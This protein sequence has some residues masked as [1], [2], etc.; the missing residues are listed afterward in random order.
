VARRP[1][2]RLT[3]IV[4][5]LV[6][7]LVVLSGVSYS[8]YERARRIAHE[9][10]RRDVEVRA[11][12]LAGVLER[13]KD[14][15]EFDLDPSAVTEY[16]TVGEAPFLSIADAAGKVVVKSP[17]LGELDFAP[18]TDW[19][20]DR[21]E[22]EELAS[23]PHGV[24]C[25]AVT[26]SF[27]VRVDKGGTKPKPGR[28][29]WVPPTE[30]E[31]R[32]NIHVAVDSRDRDAALASLG[33]F[34]VV[35]DAVALL[36]TLAGGLLLARV[37]LR[38]IRRMTTEAMRL[39]AESPDQ[40]LEPSAI[41]AELRVLAETLNAAFDR[42]GGAL[43]RQR[44]FTADAGHELRTPVTTLLSNTEVLLERVRKPEEYV[45]GLQLQKRTTERMRTLVEDLL[46]LARADSDSGALCVSSTALST[47]FAD[48][49][50]ELQSVAH[51]R[52][53]CLDVERVGGSA[54]VRCDGEAMLRVLRN[55]V[56]NALKFTPEG[57][58]VRVA[59]E[60]DERAVSILVSDSGPGIPETD[61]ERVFE[62]F[63]RV[64][65]G[66]D[67]NEGSGLG[68]AIARTLVSAQGGEI[69]VGQSTGGGAVFRVR[70]RRAPPPTERVSDRG[71]QRR[72]PARPGVS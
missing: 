36:L 3:L 35:A 6:L 63:F 5:L 69:S 38:P 1:S 66:R 44:R 68:L 61:R 25:A 65:E 34:L 60:V 43:D 52:D 15:H 18:N 71:A 54:H 32:Y 26:Y 2:L 70:L 51:A 46:T 49:V 62:R 4:G 19:A 53:V 50:A 41:V 57:G 24:P 47:L 31:R 55:L 20:E 16:T 72:A 17:S 39:D 7:Q 48:V 23:G 33:V 12:T 56:S 10:L 28:E 27:R 67:R 21:M 30:A 58:T 14:G 59:A 40:R 45:E 29:A 22:H 64:H 11:R 9:S 13:D 37:V 42:L 8:M